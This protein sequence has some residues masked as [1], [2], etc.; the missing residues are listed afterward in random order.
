M[1]FCLNIN[2]GVQF[3]LL[4]SL[5]NAVLF[6]QSGISYCGRGESLAQ[7]NDLTIDISG[8]S[9]IITTSVSGE[10]SEQLNSGTVEVEFMIF[11][12]GILKKTLDLCAK[13]EGRSS[14][15]INKGRFTIPY[16]MDAPDNL[17]SYAG[18][19]TG[20]PGSNFTANLQLK[21]SK[22]QVLACAEVNMDSSVSAEQPAIQALSIAIA[23]TTAAISVAGML[24]S[25]SMSAALPATGT[26]QLRAGPS[27][28]LLDVFSTF[29]YIAMTGQLS[30]ELPVF[31]QQFSS[32]F[33]WAAG[34]IHIGF[35]DMLANMLRPSQYEVGLKRRGLLPDSNAVDY[36]HLS[37]IASHSRKLGVKPENYFITVLFIF[38][39]VTVALTV[40]F[41]L[42]RVALE[43]LSVYRP[44]MFTNVRN[45]F[46]LYYIGNLLRVFLLCYFILATAALYQ[47]TL[48]DF[49][50][51]TFSAVI[52]LALFCLG[53]MGFVAF[54][55]TRAGADRLYTNLTLQVK[56]GP[57]YSDYRAA[58]Y[59][60]FVPV[61]VSAIVRAFAVGILSKYPIA[62]MIILVLT[63]IVF[64]GVLFYYRPYLLK[65]NNN[66]M[67]FIGVLRIV[68]T[69]LMFAFIGTS[70]SDQIVRNVIGIALV[71]VQALMVLAI[72]VMTLWSLIST[73]KKMIW[74]SN[75]MTPLNDK[76]SILDDSELPVE[77]VT[78][79]QS[80]TLDEP[81]DSQPMD[82]F[83]SSNTPSVSLAPP[84]QNADSYFPSQP[85]Y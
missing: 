45:H 84:G 16:N 15:P 53:L 26:A 73:V 5:I 80:L 57:L 75:E 46:A 54:R 3:L 8:T 32:N 74:G 72:L 65:L 63:E 78:K 77:I 38:I 39:C 35:L 14:C 85:K 81:I 9:K 4:A 12:N 17:S 33:A 55:V 69:A 31:S 48:V 64:F 49:W 41:V 47:L 6:K 44:N 70:V 13:N 61:L 50:V 56:Y 52:V 2:F 79:Q 66:L 43:L 23:G 68:S 40:I 11:G 76:S 29:Q 37:G 28:C 36:S 21:N 82:I 42:L 18:L 27:P 71:A 58:T 51:V 25:T 7:I 34:V 20:I 24:L 60:F 22:G 30:L 62:Q 19:V 59:I 83:R 10:V 1:H 67:V